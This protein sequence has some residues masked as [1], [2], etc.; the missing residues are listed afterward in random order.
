MLPVLRPPIIRDHDD[1]YQRDTRTAIKHLDILG[2]QKSQVKG[3]VLG[4]TTVLVPHQLGKLPIAWQVTDLNA[5]AVVFRD[6]TIATTADTI[7]LKASATVTV[8]L[9]FW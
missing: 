3:V 2:A 7:P 4:A 8:D 6:P 5:S 1:L 9:Q